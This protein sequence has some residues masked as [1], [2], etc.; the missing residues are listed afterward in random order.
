MELWI[1]LAVIAAIFIA[2]R[3]YISFDIFQ[4]YSYI[5]YIIY[6]NIVVFVFT[7]MYIF[8]SKRELKQPENH[9]IL[10][11][12]LRVLL[13]LL[14]IEPC[15]Y[16]SIKYCSNPG[17]V[18]ALVN[19]NSIFLILISFLLLKKGKPDVYKLTGLTSMVLGSYLIT[20]ESD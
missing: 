6:T 10:I 18:K 5:D 15:I 1:M 16:Y 14:I 17:Y 11:I 20:R 7:L 13:L 12:I 19:L 3:D 2:V 8:S 9:D 4:K